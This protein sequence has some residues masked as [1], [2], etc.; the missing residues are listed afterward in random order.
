MTTVNFANDDE[1]IKAI[2]TGDESGETLVNFSRQVA[3]RLARD[4]LGNAQMRNFFTEV[5]Q[6]QTMWNANQE[7]SR[8]DALRRLNMLKPKLAYQTMRERKV[9]TLRQVL[10]KCIEYVNLAGKPGGDQDKAFK[11]FMDF[12]EA[13]L[14]YHYAEG[15]R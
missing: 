2:M 15:V 9:E 6:I 13:I 8:T 14:A 10:T 7:G 1:A 5:R 4:G 3:E 11:R 12:F